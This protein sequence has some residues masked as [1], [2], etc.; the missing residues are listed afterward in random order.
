[1]AAVRPTAVALVAAGPVVVP[2][3]AAARAAVAVSI[4]LLVVGLVAGWAAAVPS[5]AG[6][7]IGRARQAYLRRKAVQTPL[8]A[9]EKVGSLRL[10]AGRRRLRHHIGAAG[11][12]FRRSIPRRIRLFVGCTL[13]IPMIIQ[14][15]RLDPSGTDGASNVS[16]PDPSG[17]VQ[18][19][20][21]HPSRKRKV[22]GSNPTSGSK[23]Q[24][25]RTR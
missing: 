20:A 1:V 13:I 22:E 4:L 23:D 18:V 2:I 11:H 7:P 17:A 8:Q 24:Q 16:R 14:T 19:D 3:G 5:R 9:S 6:S 10:S 12:S 21:G 15:I 25:L